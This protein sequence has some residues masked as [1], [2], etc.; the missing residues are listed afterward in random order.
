MGREGGGAWRECVDADSGMDK[1]VSSPKL[2][3]GERL[4]SSAVLLRGERARDGAGR[5]TVRCETGAGASNLS[6]DGGRRSSRALLPWEELARSFDCKREIAYCSE[7]N[8]AT[9]KALLS[10]LQ[11]I[12]QV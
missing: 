4:A 10:N 2:V 3:R 1:A 11:G 8:L 9:G 5:G 7:C 12:S 6:V